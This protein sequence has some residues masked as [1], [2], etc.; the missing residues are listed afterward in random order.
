MGGW[1]WSIIACRLPAVPQKGGVSEYG[2]GLAVGV[3]V[4]TAGSHYRGG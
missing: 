1:T 4:Y 2:D 3:G